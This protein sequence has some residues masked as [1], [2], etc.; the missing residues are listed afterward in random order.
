[1]GK[2]YADCLKGEQKILTRKAAARMLRAP[3]RK[4]NEKNRL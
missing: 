2:L 4:R 3:V 1:M